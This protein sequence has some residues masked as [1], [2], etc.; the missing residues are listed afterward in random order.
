M[1]F[2]EYRY[3]IDPAGSATFPVDW[4]TVFGNTHPIQVEIGFGYGEFLNQM[5]FDKPDHNF[6]GI[7]M[8]IFSAAK[9]QRKFHTRKLD[10]IRLLVCDARFVLKNLFP[11]QSV[12]KVYLNFP[13]PWSK[14]RHAERRVIVPDFFETLNNSISG[15][16]IF[17]ISTDVEE[18]VTEAIHLGKLSGFQI[19]AYCKNPD[20]E[21]MTRFERKWKKFDRDIYFLQL[22]KTKM[23]STQKLLEG[24]TPMP[25]RI[26]SKEQV[27]LEAL[28]DILNKIYKTADEKEICIFKSIYKDMQWQQY[29]IKTIATDE[30]FTQH[31]F[32]VLVDRVDDWVVKLDG[33]C[34]PYRTPAVKFAVNQL[35]DLLIR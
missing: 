12:E 35:A 18:Y 15:D 29:L 28:P 10:N 4:K 13:C 26:L 22:R 2:E 1:A 33:A 23:S 27:K 7:E 20:R 17:E 32:M 8:S 25:H 9:A 21:S 5:A 31:F 34:N 11:A 30:N 14:A 24:D 19:Q 6:V 3:L 16:G